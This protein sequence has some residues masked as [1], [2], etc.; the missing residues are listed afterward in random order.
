MQQKDVSSPLLMKTQNHNWTTTDKKM[1]EPTKKD[2]LQPKTKKKPQWDVRRDT[3][4][5]KS[6]PIPATWVTHRLENNYTT[7][8]LPQEWKFW[9]PHQAPQPGGLAMGGGAP[10]ES[11]FE[12]QQDVITGSPQDWGKQ[13]LHSWRVHTR[14]GVH[15]DPRKKQWL[16]KSQGQTY[17]LVLEGLLQRWGVAM[18]QSGDK[19]TGSSSSGEYSLGWALLKAAIF[20]PRPGPTQQP[21][22]SSAGMPQAKQPQGRNKAPH[23][24]RRDA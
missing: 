10:R 7:E 4:T 19:S 3:V 5:I 17:L 1:L 12:G 21:V 16:H 24:S 18:A 14:S 20:S 22:G 6:N 9:A 23:I 15:Q 11:G 2:P 13:K 8:V